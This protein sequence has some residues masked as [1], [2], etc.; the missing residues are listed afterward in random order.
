MQTGKCFR[1]L[2]L[3]KNSSCETGVGGSV[4][5]SLALEEILQVVGFPLNWSPFLGRLA[6]EGV[7]LTRA[8]LDPPS[9]E[10]NYRAWGRKLPSA[11]ELS[12]RLRSR[13]SRQGERHLLQ[14]CSFQ[15]LG[16]CLYY[17]RYLIHSYSNPLRQTGLP[18]RT[19]E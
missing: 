14:A 8:S 7:K 6:I 17:M 19:R 9:S 11:H 3:G 1:K 2:S 18:P 12:W 16:K 10:Q 13:E 5:S 15:T 4:R